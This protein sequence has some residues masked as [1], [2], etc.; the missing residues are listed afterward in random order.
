MSFAFILGLEK[1]ENEC[2]IP[3]VYGEFNKT[4]RLGE[5]V[6]FKE[7]RKGLEVTTTKIELLPG[8]YTISLNKGEYTV[9]APGK[10]YI[11]PVKKE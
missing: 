2:E 8:C 7:K 1:R 10:I 6:E 4:P 11:G 5:T 3:K 9:R